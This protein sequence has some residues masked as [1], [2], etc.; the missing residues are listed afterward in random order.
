MNIP[1]EKISETTAE[2]RTQVLIWGRDRWWIPRAVLLVYLVK[3]SLEIMADSTA[4]TWFMPVNLGIHETGHVVFHLLGFR[5]LE[6]AGGTIAQLAAPLCLIISFFRQYDLFAPAFGAFW[7]GTNVHYV[8]VYMADARAQALPLVT[9][10]GGD[11]IIH[12]WNYM[13]GKLGLLRLD[14]FLASLVWVLGFLIM[15]GSCAYGFWVCRLISEANRP[16][17]TSI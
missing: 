12:D 2:L 16:D 4:W 9:V 15:W 17:E 8:S 7:L 6:I 5:F 3:V 11:H 14:T 10:G 1:W 13:L